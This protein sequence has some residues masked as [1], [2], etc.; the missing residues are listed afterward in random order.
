MPCPGQ[1]G[2]YFILGTSPI[3]YK[4][5]LIELKIGKNLLI[6]QLNGKQKTQKAHSVFYHV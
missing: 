3:F 5:S 2:T 6:H 1:E 4:K